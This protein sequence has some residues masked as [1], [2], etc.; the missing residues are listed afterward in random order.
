MWK[1]DRLARDL[2][3]QEAALGR[4]WRHDGR[5]FTVDKGE[6]LAD[7]PADPMRTAFRQMLGV[8]A[9]LERGMI[10]ARMDAGRQAKNERAGTSA[11]H[12][13]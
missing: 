1:L 2:M 7:D 13:R 9:Q 6:I 5:V 12:R 8:F 10:R 4:V 3:T 11:A